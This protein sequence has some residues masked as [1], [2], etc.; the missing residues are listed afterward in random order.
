MTTL[1]STIFNKKLSTILSVR[2]FKVDKL[3]LLVDK[4]PKKEQLNSIKGVKQAFSEILKINEIKIDTYD[5]FSIAKKIINIIENISEDEKIYVDISQS[6][7]SQFLG[8]LLGCYA[9]NGR[10]EKIIYRPDEK[11]AVLIPK[12][13]LKV[14][15][16]KKKILDRIENVKNLTQLSEDLKISRTMLY[17]H[18]AYLEEAGFIIK[19][20]NKFK[21]TDAG[22]IASL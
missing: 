13:R 22:K 12:L 3:I 19:D 14:D 21:I 8:V 16:A 4:D 10:V 20:G 1:I 6:Q 7:K 17:K 2:D 11:T 9:R 15:G 5:L 18:L